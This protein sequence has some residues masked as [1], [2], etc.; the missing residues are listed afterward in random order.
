[1]L[2]HLQGRPRL[3]AAAHEAEAVFIGD[4]KDLVC[5]LFESDTLFIECLFVLCLVV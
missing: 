3:H 2:Y 5:P 4:F 1:M